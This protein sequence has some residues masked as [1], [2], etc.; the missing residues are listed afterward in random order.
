VSMEAT[1]IEDEGQTETEMVEM[2][3]GGRDSRD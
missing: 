1:L 2:Q 3:T